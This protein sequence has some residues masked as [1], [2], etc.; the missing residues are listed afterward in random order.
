MK[1][2]DDPTRTTPHQIDV[3]QGY[4]GTAIE[5][6]G[7]ALLWHFSHW[8]IGLAVLLIVTGAQTKIDAEARM[9]HTVHAGLDAM[10]RRA[11]SM[12]IKIDD[13]GDDDHNYKGE[14][15]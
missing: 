12:G 10:R 14:Q 15:R 9:N 11:A 8:T 2:K 7:F 1:A 5:I 4:V 13:D 6:L 3:V